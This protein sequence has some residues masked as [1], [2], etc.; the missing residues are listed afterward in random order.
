MKFSGVIIIDKSD[1]H[2]QGQGRRSKVNVTKVKIKS[3]NVIVSLPSVNSNRNSS[4]NSHM[5]IKRCT[6]LEVPWKR[7][8]I[9]FEGH[10]SNFKVTLDKKMPN[11]TQLLS[12]CCVLTNE[13][14]LWE[15][16]LN[17]LTLCELV[18]RSRNQ[19]LW[20]I[21]EKCWPLKE[22]DLPSKRGRSKP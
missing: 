4:V 17:W 16:T 3:H 12:K 2:A 22:R 14:S 6:K 8:H 15:V 1:V 7:C 21:R 19:T 11:L 20:P 13:M 18:F 5:A 9:V 10:P